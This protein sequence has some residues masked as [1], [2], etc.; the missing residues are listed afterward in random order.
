M[1]KNVILGLSCLF[2]L[3]FIISIFRMSDEIQRKEDLIEASPDVMDITQDIRT[4]VLVTREKLNETSWA[5]SSL[6]E[7]NWKE[8]SLP[9]Y[10]IIKEKEFNEN[11]YAYYRIYI[12]EKVT[13]KFTHLKG[14]LEF[15]PQYILFGH[16]DVFVNGKFY[17]SS[18]P[19]NDGQALM[20]IP[21]EAGVKNIVAIQ[22][23]I[24]KGSTG[25]NHRGKLFLGKA[26]ELYELHSKNYMINTVFP[27]IYILCKGSVVFVFALIYLLLNV[28]RSFETF[29]VFSLCVVGEDIMTGDFLATLITL[30]SRVYFYNF[31]NIVANLFLFLFLGDVV[32]KNLKKIHLYSIFCLITVFSFGMSVDILHTGYL[33][34]F[35]SYLQAWNLISTGV[36]IFYLPLILKKEKILFGVLI[37]VISLTMWGTFFSSNVGLNYKMFGNLLLFF[38]V[39]YQSFALFRREQVKSQAQ[40]IQLL[41]QEKDVAIGKTAS[42]L[43]HDV[44][45][46]LEQMKLILDKVSNGQVSEE[47]LKAAKNDVSFSITSVNNQINDIMNYSKSRQAELSVISFYHVLSGSLKQIMTINKGMNLSLEFDFTAN[48]KVLGDESRLSSALTNLISNAVEA[49]RDIGKKQIGNIRFKT[50]LKDQK[51]VFKIFNDGPLI[52]E[53]VLA[54]IWKPLFTHGKES[55]T[56]LGLSSVVKTIND[57]KGSISVRNVGSTGVEFEIQIQASGVS[58]DLNQYEFQKNSSDYNYEIK[59]I[60]LADKR[61]LRIFLLDDDMQVEEYFRFLLQN[62]PFQVELTFASHFETARTLVQSKRFDLYILDYDLGDKSNGLEFYHECLPFLGNEIV[63]HSGREQ[64]I[65]NGENCLHCKKPMSFEELNS[66]CEKVYES[67]L[68]ILLIDDSELTRMTWEMFHGRQNIELADSPET[69]LK[70][71]TGKKDFDL[72]VVDF[73]FDN[74]KMNG[75]KLVLK[76]RELHPEMKIVLASNT[77]VSVPGF[78]TIDKHHFDVRNIYSRP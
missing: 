6:D 53:N 40:E 50:E 67:R 10:E 23:L 57:H 70:I 20:N 60:S 5:S 74:S 12:P 43:A 64:S 13:S 77:D 34:N 27:L 71:L 49:I 75:E 61:P 26:S 58:D 42:L 45:R 73:Y 4:K 30:N 51:F 16:Y 66:L 19:K 65:V 22:G 68:K 33:F 76:I 21:V 32:G 9:G 48:V 46:P 59:S 29:L 38:M 69:A 15:S 52:P 78:K 28:Q 31:L 41:E 25:I 62:L 35:N 37:S 39:A 54:E 36:I 47:F 18:T 24:H 63:I 72:C 11:S 44:R 8:V 17:K 56:G 1:K 2:S 7:K 14:E 55:G 3:L